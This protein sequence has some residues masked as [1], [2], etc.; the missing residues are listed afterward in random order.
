MDKWEAVLTATFPDIQK[1]GKLVRVPKNTKY[2]TEW[3]LRFR[4]TRSNEEAKEF[5]EFL[6][7]NLPAKWPTEDKLPELHFI[8]SVKIEEP[9]PT[10]IDDDETEPFRW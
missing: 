7:A 4:Y 6:L 1:Y 2:G 10:E 3:Q 9:K 5:S 8:P